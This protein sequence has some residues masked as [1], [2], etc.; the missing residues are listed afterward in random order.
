MGWFQ[1]KNRR[2]FYHSFRWGK[3]VRTRYLGDDS[4]WSF[5]WEAESDLEDLALERAR[6]KEERRGSKRA[7]EEEKAARA[8]ARR[9]ASEAKRRQ[10]DLDGADAAFPRWFALVGSIVDAVMEGFGYHR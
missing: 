8:A 9:E 10:R 1:R 7:R 5:A 2:Y 4:P 3:A 6:S